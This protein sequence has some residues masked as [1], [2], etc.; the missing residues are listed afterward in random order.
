M[1]VDVSEIE[2]EAARILV[3]LNPLSV[4]VLA[5]GGAGLATAGPG[6]RGGAVPGGWQ[7]L[8]PRYDFDGTRLDP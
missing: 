8:R 3:S 7:W 1:A 5:A 2:R 4:A 6:T